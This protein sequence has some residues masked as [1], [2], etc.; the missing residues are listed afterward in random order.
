M[1]EIRICRIAS[2]PKEMLMMLSISITEEKEA[3]IEMIKE[4]RS[5]MVRSKPNPE[6]PEINS[7][8]DDSECL[9]V[10]CFTTDYFSSKIEFK[11]R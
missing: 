6:L 7:E 8:K 9:Y 4:K 3:V 11:H 2:S 5:D 10:A 1:P